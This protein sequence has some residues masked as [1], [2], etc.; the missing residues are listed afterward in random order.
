MIHS[1][2]VPPIH[3]MD[4]RTF[5]LGRSWGLRPG[6]WW[7]ENDFLCWKKIIGG[8]FQYHA[9]GFIGYS[10]YSIFGKLIIANDSLVQDLCDNH[11][12]TVH[13]Q[14]T[15]HSV[16]RLFTRNKLF[17]MSGV[18]W[19]AVELNALNK[20]RVLQASGIH[21]PWFC[22]GLLISLADRY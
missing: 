18:V 4:L 15:D 14:S 6:Y 16:G 17:K 20:D 7:S 8:H 13:R 10:C 1:N 3:V 11:L 9:K 21:G 19:T 2:A 5:Q 12:R 22:P